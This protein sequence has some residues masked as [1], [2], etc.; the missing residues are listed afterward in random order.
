[1]DSL[2]GFSIPELMVVLVILGIITTL[3]M[4]RYN[5]YV[6]KGRQAEAKVNLTMI[7]SLQEVWKFSHSTYNSGPGGGGVGE[8]GTDKCSTG[9]PNS[10]MKNEL[11]FR[12]KD[13]AKLR[14][15]YTWDATD[16]HANSHASGEEIYPGCNKVD[17]W[18]FVYSNANLNNNQKIVKLCED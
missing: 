14:Y 9:T 15:G 18:T 10:Q 13:C 12:P 16:A 3:G 6:A 11:G 5:A 8:F 7:G 2:R 1:M 17:K 4:S